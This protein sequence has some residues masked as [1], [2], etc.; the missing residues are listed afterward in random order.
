MDVTA[1]IFHAFD[2]LG[3]V[4][5]ALSGAMVAVKKRA[6]LFGILF[7]GILTA[8]GGGV[9]RDVLLGSSPPRAF[10]NSQYVTV[11]ALSALLLFFVAR[12]FRTQYLRREALVDGVNN[13]F[14]AL[15]LGVFSVTGVQVAQAAGHGDN[16]F[17]SVFLGM[18]TGV[19]GGLLRDVSVNEIPF[20]L[21]K[22]IYAVASIL[23]ALSY[24][25]LGRAGLADTWAAA[26]SIVL[27]FAVRMLATRYRWNL[28]RVLD[29]EQ[30]ASK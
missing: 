13:V 3:T 12:R 18:V 17:F 15:G 24:C 5:F 11:A 21:T 30:A 16:L 29:G 9:I 22:R 6:D 28:P 2:L 27:V 14:D 26:V 10:T 4:S 25:L 23:G 8:V 7:L 20:V 19:G 1:L